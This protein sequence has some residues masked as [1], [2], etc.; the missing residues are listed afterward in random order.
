MKE[1]V[2]KGCKIAVTGK[3]KYFTRNGINEKMLEAGAKPCASVT[4]R[5]DFVIC[6][7]KPGRKLSMAEESGIPVLTEEQFMKMMTGGQ[8][9]GYPVS[10]EKC[11]RCSA[12]Q[13]VTKDASGRMLDGEEM[14]YQCIAM[15]VD[16]CAEQNLFQERR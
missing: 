13:M 9:P 8:G 1:N 5:T 15:S 10:R 4:G 2:F 11:G 3:L 7:A 6:G 14:Y 12:C 16:V